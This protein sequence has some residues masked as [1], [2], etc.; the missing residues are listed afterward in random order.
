[1]NDINESSVNDLYN[2]TVAA[3]PRT[4]K[5]QHATQPIVIEELTWTPFLGMKT[6]FVKSAVRNETRHYNPIILFKNI[7]YNG[8]GAKIK[9]NNG[10][11]YE[12]D[13]ISVENTDIVLRCQCDDFYFRFNYY[14]HLDH[15]LYGRKRGAYE[16]KG[17]GPPA[18]PMELPGMCKHLIKT[19]QIMQE[20]RI[21]VE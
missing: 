19:I 4:T 8:T 2:S 12:F 21:F 6:L 5:R 20:Y 16:S 13:P 7:N 1:M 14:N 11:L 17:I 3:F 9:D 15:S 18:N 10:Q